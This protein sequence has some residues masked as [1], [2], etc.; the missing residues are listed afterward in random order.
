MHDGDLNGVQS[1]QSQQGEEEKLQHGASGALLTS[2]MT[3]MGSRLDC[4]SLD[5]AT[6]LTLYSRKVRG[7]IAGLN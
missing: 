5:L 3:R 7:N 4:M 2:K 6:K 1:F